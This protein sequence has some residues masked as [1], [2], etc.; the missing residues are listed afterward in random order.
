MRC[1]NY[2]LQMTSVDRG[3]INARDQNLSQLDP[4]K[5][6]FYSKCPSNLGAMMG[7]FIIV[8]VQIYEYIFVIN[9]FF[10]KLCLRQEIFQC[11]FI[12]KLNKRR[13]I[14][15]QNILHA[16]FISMLIYTHVI[17]ILKVVIRK[18]S[19]MT[20]SFDRH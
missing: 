5:R 2:F 16:H 6:K 7:S 13:I 1:T 14:I 12:E 18:H 15:I 3:L 19:N 9:Y 8:A 17:C 20:G 11:L 4:I 10:L